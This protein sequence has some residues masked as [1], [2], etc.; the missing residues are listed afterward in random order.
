ML[1]PDQAEAA[2]Q[3]ALALVPALGEA[4]QMLLALY[5]RQDRLGDVAA[6]YET[7]ATR[8]SD[9]KQRAE[10]LI[11]AAQLYKDRAGRPHDA[12]AALLAA[13]SACPD[14]LSLTARVAD[15]LIELGRRQDAADFDAL[16]IES[17]PFHSSFDRHTAWLEESGDDLSLA[18]VLSLRAEATRGDEA[19]PLWLKAAA[20]FRRAGAL[21]RAQVCEAQAF[22]ASPGNR[23]AFQ[24]LLD[25]A[26]GEPRRQAELLAI[27]ARA[28]PAEASTLLRQRAQLLTTAAESLLASAAWDEYLEQIPDDLIA[29]E[30]RGTLAAEAGGARAAQPFDR[31]LVQ[32][33]GETLPSATRLAV[34]TR[35]GRA[36]VESQAWHD[37]VDAFEAAFVIDPDSERGK[38]ALS[39]LN[40]AYAR[41]GDAAGQYSTTMRLAARTTGEEAE[42]LHRRALSLHDAPQQAIGALE[43]LLERHPADAALYQKGLEAYRGAGPGGR[44]GRPARAL[45]RGVRWL[46]G[47]QGAAGRGDPGGDRAAGR[48]ARLRA[49]PGCLRS[50]SQRHGGRRGGAHRSA[51][52]G[53]RRSPRADAGAH[54]DG[55][56][57][58]AAGR[59]AQAGAGRLA[60]VAQAVRGR[61]HA[62]RVHPPP[63]RGRSRLLAGAGR[64]RAH[65]L[66]A[67]GRRGARRRA[68]RLRRADGRA[69]ARRPP[70][71][72]RAA[73]TARPGSSPAR[74]S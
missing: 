17:D 72:G 20:A 45:R 13:R 67:V 24:T 57:R 59:R 6:Y 53:R 35:L 33:G 42:A 11:R 39:M 25:R 26:E 22:E 3:Q 43:W 61:A 14:D 28:V 31:R 15:L 63:G 48:P 69:G 8:A 32:L 21:E 74:C 34:W 9:P 62:A 47:R 49:A 55:H 66:R 16:L 73:R 4:E 41:L 70:A 30:A 10:L 7:A 2:L 23:E 60:R 40:E 5:E 38:E 36:A 51:P 37:A 1:A 54:L 58:R 68:A 44:S 71:R 12:A 18:G 19:G 56:P 52:P 65:R 46:D 64:P 50:R 27:R 29:L